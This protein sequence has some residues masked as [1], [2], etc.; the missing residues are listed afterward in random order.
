MVCYSVTD[1]GFLCGN[2]QGQ[3]VKDKGQ[4]VNLLLPV[5]VAHWGQQLRNKTSI[6]LM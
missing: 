4:K 3:T 1:C 6:C 2:T 5:T